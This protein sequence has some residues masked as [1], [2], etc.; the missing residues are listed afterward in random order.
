MKRA[1]GLKLISVSRLRLRL[2]IKQFAGAFILWFGWCK[3]KEKA[4]FSTS[5][6]YMAFF[7]QLLGPKYSRSLI[8][9]DS[10]EYRPARFHLRLRI[11]DSGNFQAATV[12]QGDNITFVSEESRLSYRD[13]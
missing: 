6:E 5:V 9:M 13:G 11:G 10:K 3:T 4:M 2:E 8:C 1:M 12:K 7:T